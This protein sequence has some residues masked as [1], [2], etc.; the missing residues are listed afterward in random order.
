MLTL[1]RLTFSYSGRAPYLIHDISLAVPKGAYLSI[2]GE[3]GCGKST[4]MKLILGF[5]TPLSG[6]VTC[7]AR[8]I[9]YVPQRSDEGNAAFPITVMEVMESYRHLLHIKDPNISM[10]LLESMGAAGFSRALMGHLSGG[11]HQKVLLARALLGDPD[12]LI[13]DEPSTGI[14]PESQKDIYRFLSRLNRDKGVTII[15]VEHN[16]P[17]ARAHSTMI[18]HM[19]DGHIVSVIPLCHTL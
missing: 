17:A 19:A 18:A 3:N 4:L 11:Q 7:R 14:D 13:L 10:E 12:L 2:T 8:R 16:L 15:A 1:S 5:L 6:S 9:G